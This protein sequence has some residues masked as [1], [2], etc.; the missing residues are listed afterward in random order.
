MR[1][2]TLRPDL[3]PSIGNTISQMAAMKLG[4]YR[5]AMDMA[6]DLLARETAAKMLESEKQKKK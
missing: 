4:G 6:N 3:E 2:K 5:T 1:L